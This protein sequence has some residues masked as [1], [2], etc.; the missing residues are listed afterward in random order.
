[1]TGLSVSSSSAGLGRSLARVLSRFP[2]L[3]RAFISTGSAERLRPFIPEKTDL[4]VEI[5]RGPQRDPIVSL[6]LRV[7]V[8]SLLAWS[9]ALRPPRLQR[10]KTAR[11]KRHEKLFG[12]PDF[13]LFCYCGRG[14]GGT[15]WASISPPLRIS[16]ALLLP[17]FSCAVVTIIT[18]VRVCMCACVCF[19]RVHARLYHFESVCLCLDA[20][21][22]ARWTACN[23]SEGSFDWRK[24]NFPPIKEFRRL[25]R[26][27]IISFP[28]DVGALFVRFFR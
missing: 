1:M 16:E 19:P 24:L 12:R 8:P 6:L 28:T 25:G 3:S 27:P 15:F 14:Y 23:G 20:S 11:I 21:V 4:G 17:L 26:V 22:C 7:S 13:C 2:P 18:F 9:L 10:N 5:S